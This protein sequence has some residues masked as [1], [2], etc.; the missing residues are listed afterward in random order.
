MIDCSEDLGGPVRTHQKWMVAGLIVAVGTQ[1]VTYALTRSV[2]LSI[3]VGGAG[4]AV[5]VALI[6]HGRPQNDV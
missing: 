3:L 1:P 5:G 6:L 4:L 2:W